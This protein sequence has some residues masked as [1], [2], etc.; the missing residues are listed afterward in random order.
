MEKM[1]LR[2]AAVLL[3]LIMT[4]L[5]CACNT[6]A[7]QP[8]VD[9]IVDAAVKAALEAA[10][11][12]VTVTLEADGQS[13]SFEDA[14]NMTV[15]QMLGMAEITLYPGD[16]LTLAPEQSLWGNVTLQVLRRCTVTVVV[17]GE[18][19]QT[20]VRHTVVLMG[21][22]VAD[23]LAAVGVELGADQTVSPAPNARLENGMEI[24]IAVKQTQ[25]EGV[26][27]TEPVSNPGGNTNN[28]TGSNT[29][30]APTTP[31][32]APTE[33]APAPTEPQRTV[34][35]VEIYE[36]CDGSGHGVQVI[37]YS[38]GTQEEVPF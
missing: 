9:A 32:P 10:S 35:S 5:L 17:P 38:D 33:P 36:D 30:P 31:A 28:N 20:A 15:E 4:V 24:V 19:P 12:P 29:P 8:S 21:G 37:T 27:A 22:T 26:E 3:V 25:G 14:Q 2:P 7:E 11:A 16:V 23:A 13:I 34:V 1:L 18:E 6:A